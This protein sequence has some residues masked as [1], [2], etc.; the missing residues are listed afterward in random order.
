MRVV[1]IGRTYILEVNR[2]KWAYLPPDVNLALV[3]PPAVRHHLKSV[4]G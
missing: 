2:T 4:L 1:V 3:T